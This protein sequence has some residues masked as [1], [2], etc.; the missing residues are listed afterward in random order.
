MRSTSR[1]FIATTFIIMS[2]TVLTLLLLNAGNEDVLMNTLIHIENNYTSA[3][4]QESCA[5]LNML[6]NITHDKDYTSCKSS[7]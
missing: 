4:Y 5:S 3:Y 2:A 1:G 6:Q 7:E